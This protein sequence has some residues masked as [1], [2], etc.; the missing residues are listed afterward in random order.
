MVEKAAQKWSKERYG[1]S[2]LGGDRKSLEGT[3]NRLLS[4]LP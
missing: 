4:S 2:D 3:G 1:A